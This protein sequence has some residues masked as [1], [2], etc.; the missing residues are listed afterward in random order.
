MKERLEGDNREQRLEQL[1]QEAQAKIE[2]EYPPEKCKNKPHASFTLFE[3]LL[4]G[5]SVE[6][7]GILD[8]DTPIAVLAGG[9]PE[10][11]RKERER[12]IEKT[13]GLPLGSHVFGETGAKAF[14]RI[15]LGLKDPG[16]AATIENIDFGKTAV[17]EDR[18]EKPLS[19]ASEKERIVQELYSGAERRWQEMQEEHLSEK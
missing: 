15:T 11:A 19:E 2:R 8:R 1:R 10:T 13:G 14:Y 4:V 7:Q 5:S 12:Y 3:H 17:V 9:N 6:G 16:A 18:S